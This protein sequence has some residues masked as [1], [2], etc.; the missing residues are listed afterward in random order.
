[1]RVRLTWFEAV[2]AGEVG[3]RRHLAAL[4]GGNPDQHGR[5]GED[6]WTVH[7]EGAAGELAVAKVL[8][9]YWSGSVNTYHDEGDVGQRLEVRT[10]SRHHYELLVRPGDPP[11]SAYVLVTGRVPWFVVR[12]WVFGH[13]AMRPE[14]LRVHGDRPAAYFVPH[15]ELSPL[16]E[17]AGWLGQR[18]VI[19]G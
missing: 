3:M 5:N 1:M 9:R 10:R 17:L 4:R 12:G 16:A 13:E 15:E 6:G 19:Q 11:D 7:I 18:D 2:M 14:W 8:D